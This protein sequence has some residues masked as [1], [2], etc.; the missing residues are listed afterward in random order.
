MSK[1][2]DKAEKWGID[3][4][5]I[6][7]EAKTRPQRN[8]VWMERCVEKI[9]A[10]KLR[11]RNEAKQWTVQNAALKTITASLIR[12]LTSM[13]TLVKIVNA[14]GVQ[15]ITNQLFTAR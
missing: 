4:E 15:T 13:I 12:T 5:P 2:Q 6:Y 3:L 8:I 7:E 10:D 1:L 11:V 9:I 14:C